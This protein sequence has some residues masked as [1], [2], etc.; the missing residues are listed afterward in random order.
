MD[1]NRLE[2]SK[3]KFEDK[4]YLNFFILYRVRFST[5]HNHLSLW[6]LLNN[7]KLLTTACKADHTEFIY[8]LDSFKIL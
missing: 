3:T 6:G 1:T 4:S 8:K 2:F 7:Q 5:I